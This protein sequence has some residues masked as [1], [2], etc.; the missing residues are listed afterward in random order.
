MQSDNQFDSELL[1]Q[2]RLSVIS[3]RRNL[4][5]L[6]TGDTDDV[7]GPSRLDSISSGAKMASHVVLLIELSPRDATLPFS[8]SFGRNL[9]AS[10]NDILNGSELPPEFDDYLGSWC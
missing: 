3:S 6:T 8:T 7:G 9:S 10:I 5:L 1:Q 2:V 4:I